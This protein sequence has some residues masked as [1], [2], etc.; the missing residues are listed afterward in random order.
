MVPERYELVLPQGGPLDQSD[1]DALAAMA[2]E[3]KWT[4]EQAQAALTEMHAQTTAQH[5]GFL[6]TL[7]AHSEV[8]GAHLEAAQVNA[9][10]AL[11]HFLPATSPEGAELRS[12]MTKSGYGNYAPLVVLL[13]RIGKA[14]AEDKG[15]STSAS[16]GAAA[17]RDAASVLYG[18]AITK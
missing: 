5:T 4:N 15:L 7:Q 9:T 1:V 17:P 2:K 13:S 8:G 18:G 3:R 16:T 6:S 12:V 11:D 14:M 10:R